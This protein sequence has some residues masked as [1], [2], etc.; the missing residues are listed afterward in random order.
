[1]GTLTFS[2]VQLAEASFAVGLTCGLNT[3]RSGENEQYGDWSNIANKIWQGANS[4]GQVNFSNQE[5]QQF[6]GILQTAMN[7]IPGDHMEIRSQ[8]VDLTQMVA[9]SY[10]SA[11]GATQT[12]AS[13]I[14][15]SPQTRTHEAVAGR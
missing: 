10:N 14:G 4:N 6:Q 11:D 1:M 3:V 12:E 8:L 7:R 5:T 9:E 2:A 13:T 15:E